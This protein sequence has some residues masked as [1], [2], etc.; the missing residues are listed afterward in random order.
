MDTFK[1]VLVSKST[2]RYLYPQMSK[3]DVIERQEL[4]IDS[5]VSCNKLLKEHLDFLRN[6]VAVQNKQ[7]E[8]YSELIVAM[9]EKIKGGTNEVDLFKINLN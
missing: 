1:P 7:I 5:L 4:E 9:D 3:E 8:L 2:Q 6:K